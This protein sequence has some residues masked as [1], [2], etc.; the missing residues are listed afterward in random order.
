MNSN[1][2]FHGRSGWSASGKDECL[3]SALNSTTAGSK[4]LDVSVCGEPYSQSSGPCSSKV[5]EGTSKL[6][7]IPG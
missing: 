4:Y 5:K 7:D 3:T 1:E 2:A 6:M